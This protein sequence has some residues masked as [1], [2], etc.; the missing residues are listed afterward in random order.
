ML[1]QKNEKGYTRY[2]GQGGQEGGAGRAFHKRDEV[3]VFFESL[4]CEAG[5]ALVLPASARSLFKIRIS[6]R[7]RI[8][9]KQFKYKNKKQSKYNK[10]ENENEYKNENENKNLKT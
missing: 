1:K 4:F 5:L 8:K 7:I 10:N 2:Q 3:I 6:I 9:K